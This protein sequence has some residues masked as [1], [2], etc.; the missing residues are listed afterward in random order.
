MNEI[1]RIGSWYVEHGGWLQQ[2]FRR[3]TQCVEQAR[4]FVNETFLKL[5]LADDHKRIECPRAFLT[6]VA[7]GL[8]VDSY[9]RQTLE[10][11]Y[12]EQ[13]S[14]APQTFVSSE[15]DRA[16]VLEVLRALDRML[17]ELPEPVRTTF[18]LSKL[19]GLSYAD[20]S[21]QTGV[22]ERT[23]KRHMAQAFEACL[24]FS[25]QHPGLI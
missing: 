14:N 2:W 5:L 13:L 11:A 19:Q 1:S 15:E 25:L 17:A 23:V 7:K 24:L 22:S 6:V 10:R 12:L 4:E 9:R 3:R 21:A 8:L 18:L 20:I 16:M